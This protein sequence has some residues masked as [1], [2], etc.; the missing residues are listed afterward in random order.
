MPEVQI[1][2]DKL[3]KLF[4]FSHYDRWKLTPGVCQSN[5]KLS[6]KHISQEDFLWQCHFFITLMYSTFTKDKIKNL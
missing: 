2:H 3:A 5:M 6:S 4:S 1:E